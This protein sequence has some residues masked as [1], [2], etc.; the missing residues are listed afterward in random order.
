MGAHEDGVRAPPSHPQAL[1]GI[2]WGE[3]RFGLWSDSKA[4]ADLMVSRK[5]SLN[6]TG[7]LL[8]SVFVL[9]LNEYN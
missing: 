3:S 6:V 2:M 7:D 4:H 1:L 5:A 9:H 8:C